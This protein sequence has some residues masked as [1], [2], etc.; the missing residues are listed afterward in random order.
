M[1]L[2]ACLRVMVALFLV[3]TACL[4]VMV[5]PLFMVIARLFVMMILLSLVDHSI[6]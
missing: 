5:G 4:P 2:L 6:S 1:E 3:V